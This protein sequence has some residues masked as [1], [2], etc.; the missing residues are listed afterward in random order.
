VDAALG[1]VIAA[2]VALLWRAPRP[3]RRGPPLL[4]E[5]GPYWRRNYSRRSFLKL[6]GAAVVSAALAY[7]GADE[8][9]QSWYGDRVRSRGTDR[10][11]RH[12]HGYGERLWFLVWTT[13]A[14]VDAY[15]G[16][17]SFSRWGRK[18]FEAML[19]G[20]PLL[21][22]LQR[23]LGANRPSDPA[24]DPRWRPLAD[25]NAASGHAFIAGIP[26]L[27]LARRLPVGVGRAVARVLSTA[28]AWSRLN[29]DKHYLSQIVLGWTIAWNATAAVDD[30]STEPMPDGGPDEPRPDPVSAA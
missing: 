14:V 27:N 18:N 7:S 8:A 19:V 22:T 20:L 23:G 5:T 24:P 4:K 2:A 25:A 9:L 6:G 1:A 15:F 28:T 29:D 10:A 17:N 21:W 12:L 13:V 3:R 26:W 16:T 30:P 11:A